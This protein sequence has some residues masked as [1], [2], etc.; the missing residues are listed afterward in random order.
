MDYKLPE[1]KQNSHKGTYG[2]VLNVAGSMY[3]PGAAYLSS[4]SALKVGCGYC[5]LCSEEAVLRSVSA[6]TQN[7]VFVPTRELKKQLKTAN[8]VSIGCGLS[9]SFRAKQIFK[10]VMDNVGDIPVII[11]A[12]GLNI[13]AKTKIKLPKQLILTPHPTEAARLMQITTEEILQD[14]K[15]WAK[16]ISKKYGCVAVLKTHQTVVCQGENTYINISGNSA[17]AKAGSGDVLTGIISGLLAQGMDLFEAAKTGVYLHGLSG[18]FASKKLTEYGVMASDLISF[19]SEAL[20][21]VNIDN[22][23]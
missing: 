9:T 21:C 5:F 3:M 13:L 17:L 1:R 11:D 2:K 8:V 18:E 7:I 15:Y 6:Q 19:L 16:E 4:V 23:S 20:L 14:T 22:F 12:D 10:K